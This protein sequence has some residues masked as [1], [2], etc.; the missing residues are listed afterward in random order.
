MIKNKFILRKYLLGFLNCIKEAVL[1]P[2]KLL[3]RHV[4]FITI[5]IGDVKAVQ[6]LFFISAVEY[7]TEGG[8]KG[9][10]RRKE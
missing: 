6:G 10:K 5:T 7:T 3:S 9:E 1:T 2:T 4:D 8:E